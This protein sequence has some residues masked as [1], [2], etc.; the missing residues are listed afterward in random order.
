VEKDVVFGLQQGAAVLKEINQEM[1]LESVEK[2][3]DNTAD[4]I[5]YQEVIHTSV[6]LISGSIEFTCFASYERGGRGGLGGVGEDASR[7]TRITGCSKIYITAKATK[8]Q[9][10]WT[11]SA[12]ARAGGRETGCIGVRYEQGVKCTFYLT[13]FLV[14]VFHSCLPS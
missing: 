9:G 10:G 3:M 2:L 12:R 1:S 6:P 4:G 7:S 11:N 13:R 8:H 5:A 14:Y